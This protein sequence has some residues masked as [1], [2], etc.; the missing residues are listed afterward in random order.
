[1]KEDREQQDQSA[2]ELEHTVFLQIAGEKDYPHQGK[3]DYAS[4]I[5]N[6]T[7]GTLLLRGTF[8]NPNVGSTPVL[9][10][11]MFAQ[12]R[13]P[14]NV[15]QDALLVPDSALR[16]SQGMQ[17]LLVVDGQNTVEERPVEIGTLVGEM[18]V[19]QTGLKPDEWVIVDGI[20]F[21]RPGAKVTPDRKSS[22]AEQPLQS[23]SEGSPPASDKSQKP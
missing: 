5:L 1:M 18:R 11:G 8:T 16:I 21:A 17:Y 12:I 6:P 15:R 10:P 20:Q 23:K 22:A 3:L 14:I 9:L 2:K 4:A 13:I 7:T 19:I